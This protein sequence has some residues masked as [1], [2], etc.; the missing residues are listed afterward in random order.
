MSLRAT[1]L[2]AFLIALN[3]FGQTV[4]QGRFNPSYLT[5]MPLPDRVISE[6]NGLNP[7]DTAAR[8]MGAFQQLNNIIT[9]MSSA[10]GQRTPDEDRIRQEYL[11]A[12]SR[13]QQTF[14]PRLLPDVDMYNVEPKLRDE[15][16]NRFFS[17]SLR[18]QLKTA[19]KQQPATGQPGCRTVPLLRGPPRLSSIRISPKPEPPASI[20]R[21]SAS[22]W[23][24]ALCSPPADFSRSFR[25][26]PPA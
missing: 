6:I 16:L 20:P 11:A 12:R 1:S 21:S 19:V 17:P 24:S 23:E 3:A 18:N 2:L 10:L 8:R 25:P 15:I 26:Q 14:D 13:V 9:E 22:L 5:E 4:R 7:I